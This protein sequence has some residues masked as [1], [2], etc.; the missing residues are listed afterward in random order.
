VT[1]GQKAVAAVLAVSLAPGAGCS[2]ISVSR[3]PPRPIDVTRPIKC[4]NWEAAPTVDAVTGAV[5]LLSGL[6][7]TGLAGAALE[8]DSGDPDAWAAFGI[9]FGAMGLGGLFGWSSAHGYS[10]VAACKEL[11]DA[12]LACLSGVE[13]SCRFLEGDPDPEAD[14]HREAEGK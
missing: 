13:T 8:G 5:F 10:N 6:V 14:G 11:M 7:L 1:A 9:G 12:Q 3:P 2:W 4:N